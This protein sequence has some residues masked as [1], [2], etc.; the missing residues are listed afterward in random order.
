MRLTIKTDDSPA[1]AADPRGQG[2]AGWYVRRLAAMSPAEIAFR[3]LDAF[4]HFQNRRRHWRTDIPKGVAAPAFPGLADEIAKL[5]LIAERRAAYEEARNGRFA[6]FGVAWPVADPPDWHLDPVTGRRWPTDVFGPS[7][8]YRHDDSYGDVKYVWE[9][10]RLQYLQPIAALAHGTGERGPAELVRRH[11][12]GWIAGNPPFRG[13]NWASGIELGLRVVSLTFAATLIDLGSD[14]RHALADS[15]AAHGWWLSRY[16]SRFSSANNHAIAEALG[17]F[18]LG[19][20]MPQLPDAAAWAARGRAIL[21]RESLRQIHPDG[22][23]AEQA[24]GYQRF[25]LEMLAL[26]AR[27]GART[28]RR[29][30]AAGRFLCAITDS[31]GNAPAIGDDDESRVLWPSIQPA[32][33]AAM[34]DGITHFPDGGYTVVREGAMHLVFDHGPLGYLS[35]AAHAHADALSVWLSVD[36]EPILIDA[37]TYGYHGAGRVRDRLRGTGMHNT[38]TIA[39]ADQSEMAG[40]FNWSRK[41]E[42]RVVGFTENPWSIEAEHDGYRRRFSSLHRRR[43]ETRG[44]GRF[45]ILDRLIGVRGPWPVSIGFLV[46]PTTA[47]RYH[48]GVWH[49]GD[50]V[51]LGYRGPLK[52][53]IE[54]TEYAPRMGQLQAT[55]RLVFTGLMDGATPS[56]FNFSLA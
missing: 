18:V 30:A 40:P 16:P 28:D 21:E 9:L 36:G 43:I 29:F 26:A 34:G 44:P 23:G 38:L 33:D 7:I 12:A 10:N 27:L 50:A 22:V 2:R 17:L 5:P 49:L 11:I 45:S 15:L 47:L 6:W 3:L 13:I 51:R 8:P 20:T 24:I 56:E 41:A 1:N 14:L 35:I 53:A 42:C 32:V 25:T 19:T 4:H 52:A 55:H 37:G 39:G 54:T 46:A 31:G 48:D